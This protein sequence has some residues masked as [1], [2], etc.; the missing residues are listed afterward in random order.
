MDKENNVFI[1][2]NQAAEKFL[3][4]Y[5]QYLKKEKD[6]TDLLSRTTQPFWQSMRLTQKRLDSMGLTEKVDMSAGQNKLLVERDGSNTVGLYS[7]E[8]ITGRE[9]WKDGKRIHKSKNAEIC[10]MSL[11]QTDVNGE[12]ACCPNCGHEAKL[13][14]Y[15]D[16]CDACGA[17]FTVQDFETKV[18]AFS[19]EENVFKKLKTMIKRIMIV[20]AVINVLLIIVGAVG[21]VMTM[22]RLLGGVNDYGTVM[23]FGGFLVSVDFVPVGITGMI[24]LPIVYILLHFV[25]LSRYKKRYSNEQIVKAVYPEFSAED[26]CQNLEYKLRNIHMTESSGQVN[27][28]AK[29]PLDEIVEKYQ[30]VVDCN[31]HSCQFLAVRKEK[32]GYVVDVEAVLKLTLF[33]GKRIRIKY[34]K[35]KLSLYGKKKVIKRK[36]VA[37]REYKCQN[38]AS[39][40]NILE[41]SI[42]KSCD[43]VFDYAD[44][45][46]V[47]EKYSI[48]KYSGNIYRKVCA[49]LIIGYLVYYGLQ[50]LSL[51]SSEDSSISL[52]Q[53]VAEIQEMTNEAYDAIPLPDELGY[54]AVLLEEYSDSNSRR[55]VYELSDTEGFLESYKGHILEADYAFAKENSTADSYVFYRMVTYDGDTGYFVCIVQL[56]GNRL[57]LKQILV[58]TLD[59]VE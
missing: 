54:D 19:L 42:C 59:E 24:S 25:L 47:I 56:D 45:G 23:A 2:M 15:I 16:G 51:G 50:C 37:L 55:K 20:L 4:F 29:C 17:R 34:E 21:F 39:S 48:E 33:T 53:S 28:F 10:C 30:S 22:L 18:S 12:M 31:M 38:C 40:I 7:R 11:L 58:E 8:V 6:D 52:F 43:S 3:H 14:T 26:F 1:K 13:E 5:G 46:W 49:L 27:V 41:G 57:E 44:Y 9:F 35:L 32:D 36:S